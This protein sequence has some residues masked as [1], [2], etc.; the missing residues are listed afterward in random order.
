ME[1]KEIEDLKKEVTN[2]LLKSAFS[3]YGVGIK[4]FHEAQK[5]TWIDFQ[6][7]IGNLSISV[8]LL[9]KSM[10]AKNAFHLL[11]SG[12]D[13]NLQVILTYP[14]SLSEDSISHLNLRRLKNFIDKT[15]KV[16]VAISLF[17][18]FYPGKKHEFKLYFDS[19]AKTRNLCVHGSIPGFKKYELERHAYFSTKLFEFIENTKFLAYSQLKKYRSD[20][21]KKFIEEYNISEINTVK[22]K[23]IRAELKA[24]N[25]EFIA[26]ESD[27]DG[28][29]EMTS[30]CPVCGQ[31][32]LLK[33]E[34]EPD[35]GDGGILTFECDSFSCESC[36]L[37][38]DSYEELQHAGM[39]TDLDR[40]EDIDEWE[41]EFLEPPY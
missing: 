40:S 33:G 38:L 25:K 12:L 26:H 11:Y 4:H 19:L 32:G 10:V 34:C 13:L 24:N 6:P 20:E 29:D 21:T 5:K 28:W 36:G 3:Y 15:I 22:D 27:A 8:E 31:I 2:N 41:K 7:A 14:D 30:T 17:K 1:N 9:L 16:D 39:E 37:S 18:I 35:Y 23:L